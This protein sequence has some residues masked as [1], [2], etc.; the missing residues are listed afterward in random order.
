M[1]YDRNWTDE[2]ACVR[3]LH[4][5]CRPLARAL[6]LLG[7]AAISPGQAGADSLTDRTDAT[8]DPTI[9]GQI[10]A[11]S[12]LTQG[13]AS[14]QIGN[15]STHL[16]QLRQGFN[17]C[18]DSKI[19]LSVAVQSPNNDL[20]AAQPTP[21]VSSVPVIGAPTAASSTAATCLNASLFESRR[22]SIW[23][24]GALSFGAPNGAA[25][26]HNYFSSPG[27][28]VGLDHELAQQLIVGA[29]FG[30]GWSDATID[31]AGSTTN[32]ISTHGSVYMHYMPVTK[33]NVD[34]VVGYGDASMDNRRWIYS[35][36]SWEHGTRRG[37]SWYGSFALSSAIQGA[38]V[39]VE[40]YLRSDFVQ[41]DLSA[42][43]ET[44][45][46]DALAF[47]AASSSSNSVTAGAVATHDIKFAGRTFTPLF[48]MSYLRTLNDMQ[49]SSLYYTDFGA[50]AAYAL[51]GSLTPQ[52]VT[53][54]EFGLRYNN[55]HGLQSE[56]GANYSM[57]NSYLTRS[58]MAKLL[59][60][61]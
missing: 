32:G 36:D 16:Q 2:F 21:T 46:A 33:V 20:S 55:N 18:A 40:P 1:G 41:S 50:G 56:L 47:G 10:Q 24:A 11:Q 25:V 53:N 45:N 48:S 14:A 37:S 12:A 52:S 35:D 7:G 9:P 3:R 61:F 38:G 34:A 5:R 26:E 60:S 59:A 23:Y 8:L 17:P 31:A 6:L 57:T 29:A 19:A 39:H 49:T 15:L 28:T 30:R 22:S 4:T 51:S 27:L 58:F 42:Y 43:N 44:G 13:F 54:R